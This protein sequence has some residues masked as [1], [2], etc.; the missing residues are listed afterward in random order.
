MLVR[1]LAA[2]GWDVVCLSCTERT[3][4]LV[5]QARV[6]ATDGGFEL[7]HVSFRPLESLPTRKARSLVR[8]YSEILRA[9]GLRQALD[10]ELARNPD[11]F[12]VEHLFPAWVAF[13]VPRTVV[14]LH[15][16]DVLDWE[17]RSATSPREAL[18]RRQ[19]QRA[20]R[21]IL[22]RTPRVIAGTER[23]RARAVAENPAVASAVVPT[24]L[25]TTLYEPLVPERPV[26]GLIGSMGWYPSRSAAVRLVTKIWPEVRRR[27]PDA[28]LLVGGRS[29]PRYLGGLFP[30]PG[31]QLVDPI[32]HPRDFFSRIGVLVYPPA[33]G[34]G[35][36]MK[37]LEAMAYGVPVISNG[38]GLEGLDY[39]N[40]R[41]AV[42]ASSDEEFV[43]RTVE[44]LRDSERRRAIGRAGRSLLESRYAP[45]AAIDRLVDSYREL[46]GGPF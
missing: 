5:E 19:L 39:E 20:T 37:V 7:R 36:K 4:D 13:G 24:I 42:L 28:Q 15:Y 45:E 3:E 25:D 43:A 16:L 12:H 33:G 30:A 23:V 34:S 27:M 1:G 11:V 2:R 44:L 26:A 22:Q 29:A 10:E 14:C 6:A 31:A 41:E 17:G 38:Y 46:L 40:G 8:P 32:D 21:R 35:M 18:S 9:P